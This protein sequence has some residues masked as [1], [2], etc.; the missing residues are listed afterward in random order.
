M[1]HASSPHSI[2]FAT[3][4]GA[5][6]PA[7]PRANREVGRA[8]VRQGA[9]VRGPRKA[10]AD[11]DRAVLRKDRARIAVRVGGKAK[12]RDNRVAIP[13]TPSQA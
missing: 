13:L 10:R 6:A 3:T 9:A 8:A 5:Q 4:A 12:V 7:N 2:A 11:V 1:K